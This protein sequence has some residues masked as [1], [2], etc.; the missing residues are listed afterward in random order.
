MSRAAISALPKLSTE[1]AKLCAE[2]FGD[3]DWVYLKP[4]HPDRRTASHLKILDRAKLKP[5]KWSDEERK[6]YN[7]LSP[8]E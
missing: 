5:F 1:I 2:V 6:A 4:T 3:N 8:K 7:A